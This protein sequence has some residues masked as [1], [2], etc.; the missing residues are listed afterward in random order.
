MRNHTKEGS[1]KGTASSSHLQKKIDASFKSGARTRLSHATE[2]YS[3][4]YYDKLRDIV[5]EKFE[6]GTPE[7]GESQ[8]EKKSRR[9]KIRRDVVSSAFEAETDEVKAEVAERL[10]ALKVARIT[11][12]A[13]REDDSDDETDLLGM[14]KY[15]TF[16]L[17]FLS[18]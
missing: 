10:E 13:T 14:A 2:I 8:R 17:I 7:D 12:A 9:L 1:K 18:Y 11:Q 5:E 16:I 4:L 15:D 6:D 3:Q